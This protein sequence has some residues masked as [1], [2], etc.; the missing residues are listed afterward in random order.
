MKFTV[1]A[2]LALLSVGTASGQGKAT[3]S[4]TPTPTPSPQTIR[5]NV[6]VSAD[7]PQ[8]IDEVSKTVNVITGQEMRE[9]ADFALSE[10]LRSIPGFR[11]QQLGGFGRTATIKTRG[12][13][14]QD[15]AVL[16]DGIRL[17]DASAITGDASP[18]LSDITLT[19]VSRI[20]VLRGSGSS[21]YGTNAIGG[22]VDLQTPKPVS[23]MHGQISYAAGGLGLQRFRGNISDGTRDGEFGFNLAVARTVYAKGID[24]Q[25]DAHNTNIQS[26]F[27][28][29]PFSRTN[30]SAR[31]FVSDAYVR[32]NANPDTLGELPISNSG[33]IF[34]RPGT[35]FIWDENDPDANQK[36][37]FFNGQI[38]LTQ[39]IDPK[40][41]LRAFYSGL[42]TSRKN[43]NGVL[44]PGFQS[45][46]TSFFDGTIQTANATINW[47]PNSVHDVKAGYEFEHE[48]FGNRGL[49]P[50]GFDDFS[51]KAFQ[52][53]NTIFVQDVSSLLNG[54]LQI[55][56]GF[57]AQFFS[58]KVPKFSLANAPYS[59]LSLNDP[60]T[61]YTFDGAASYF[62]ER[63]GTKLRAHVG[64]GYRVPSLYER[65]G[66][67][68]SS[69]GTPSF[70]ALG[71]PYLKPEKTIAFDGGVEQ[72]FAKQKVK[73]TAAYFYT[74]LIDT[75]GYG[76]FVPNIGSTTR[77]FGGYVN[78]K[79]GI[80]RGGEFSGTLKPTRSTDIFASYT[81]TNSVQRE[82]QVFGSG[83]IQTLGI[84]RHQFTFV[85]T[86]RIDRFWINAD[87]L[88]ASDYLAPIFSSSTFDTYVY[89]FNGNRRVDLTGGYTFPIK[90]YNFSLRVF[91]TI[92][93]LFGQHYFENGFRTVPRNARAGV[94]FGF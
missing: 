20:E 87:V 43:D 89:R 1:F 36:S 50:S 4:P 82:G 78:Q 3:A 58:L 40:T 41:S 92:E 62:I 77:P 81:Y 59:G 85:A 48:K 67:F 33:V 42:K 10:S 35:N 72:Y 65:F 24:G 16:I 54:P 45:A 70:V 17:R 7:Q 22:T 46:S 21:L 8:P 5:E 83:I 79:G 18:F 11:I 66:T 56:G 75:I 68:F 13:R 69:F 31:F 76:N 73:L 38:V 49:T 53:S 57:R 44:G 91:G 19:S 88:A 37:K 84:P 27:E 60:P 29:D 2:L 52:S 86:Q 26:R 71:D 94:S 61:A 14:N 51:T 93:N 6:T 9:R 74:K 15:T 28:Y 63:S 32:L 34:A 55:A 80:A 64:N 39:I 12:L 25:D 23:G 90:K 47:S 30:I